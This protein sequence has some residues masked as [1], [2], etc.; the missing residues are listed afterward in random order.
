[1]SVIEREQVEVEAPITERE[2]RARTLEGAALEI[3]VRGWTRFWPMN[4]EGQVCLLGSIGCA[5]GWDGD[6]SDGA[7][8]PWQ[9][10]FG[11]D[12]IHAVTYND[13]D[14]ESAEDVKFILRWRAAEIRDGL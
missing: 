6:D 4:P 13:D 10:T 2:Q 12:W 1:M 11:P 8:L 9:K 14:A 5:L 7:G 3:D